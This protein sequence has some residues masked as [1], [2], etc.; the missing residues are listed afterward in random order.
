MACEY[1]DSLPGPLPQWIIPRD[2]PK[3]CVPT[4][5]RFRVGNLHYRVHGRLAARVFLARRDTAL[6]EM[7]LLKINA[8]QKEWELL[9]R[10]RRD[11]EGR[12]LSEVLPEPVQCAQSEKGQQV[13][14]TRWRHEF[15][16]PLSAWAGRVPTHAALWLAHRLLEELIDLHAL[17]YR[18][19]QLSAEH[20]LIH[21]HAHGMML[22][23]WSRCAARPPADEVAVGLRAIAGVLRADVPKPLVKL[24]NHPVGS[25]YQVYEELKRV[26]DAVVGAR[27]FCPLST[28]ERR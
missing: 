9:R 2:L 25:A 12:F 3:V 17:G 14:V 4:L 19:G 24:L 8:S 21:P 1:C 22:C 27:Q 10:L 5:G 28:I 15:E 23:G 13:L 16:A 18:H 7:V 11:F 6:T 20:M 26:S